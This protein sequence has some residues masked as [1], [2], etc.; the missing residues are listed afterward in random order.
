M[1]FEFFR[2]AFQDGRF[3]PFASSVTPT[4]ITARGW[5]EVNALRETG[6]H[7]GLV[8]CGAQGTPYC[9]DVP[10]ATS[11]TATFRG[12]HG[13]ELT[14]T[15]IIQGGQVHGDIAYTQFS[16]TV[17]GHSLVLKSLARARP[18]DSILED[19]EIV[20]DGGRYWLGHADDGVLTLFHNPL[21]QR[22][23]D[24]PPLRYEGLRFS[25]STGCV[26]GYIGDPARQADGQVMAGLLTTFGQDYVATL[27]EAQGDVYIDRD[28]H[29]PRLD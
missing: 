7:P 9:A 6:Y 16:D 13:E 18:V 2:Y 29:L 21:V 15:A 26:F 20:I 25:E 10:N 12:T 22:P 11:A 4:G 24:A 1:G 23:S 8:P 27:G 17:R 3:M 14:L 28:S 19:G 5:T